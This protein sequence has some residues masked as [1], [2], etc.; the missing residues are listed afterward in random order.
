MMASFS[1]HFIETNV[2]SSP[3]CCESFSTVV[4]RHAALQ[5][6][7]V[8]KA[9]MLNPVLETSVSGVGR[10]YL[11][12]WTF[13]FRN[14]GGEFA[15]SSL[16]KCRSTGETGNQGWIPVLKGPGAKLNCGAP[17]FL[18][19]PSGLLF[20]SHGTFSLLNPNHWLSYYIIYQRT[21]VAASGICISGVH[22]VKKEK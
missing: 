9:A 7:K 4:W 20:H 10:K 6:I 5:W 16:L 13:V 2:G 1:K 14:L 15:L 22:T 8:W 17:F 3:S 12:M 19:S 18:E 11:E 21:T